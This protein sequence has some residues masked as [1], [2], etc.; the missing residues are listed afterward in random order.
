M[1]FVINI[2]ILFGRKFNNLL[3]STTPMYQHLSEIQDHIFD[4][5]LCILMF[6]VTTESTLMRADIKFS[7]LQMLHF[8]LIHIWY[9]YTD[10]FS[11]IC[12]TYSLLNDTRL[13]IQERDLITLDSCFTA[14]MLGHLWYSHAQYAKT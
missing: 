11:Q 1:W 8:Y 5:E 2:I 3:L 6:N 7:I 10:F 14:T 13:L 12:S 9:R 4:I